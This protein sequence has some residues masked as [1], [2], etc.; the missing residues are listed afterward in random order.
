MAETLIEPKAQEPIHRP[1]QMTVNGDQLV[2]NFFDVQPVK[3]EEPQKPEANQPPAEP[4]KPENNQEVKPEQRPE[5]TDVPAYLKSKWGWDSEEAADTEVRELR[6]LKGTKATDYKFENDESRNVHELLRRGKVKDV[7]DIYAKQ[8]KINN[9]TTGEVTKDN[10][11][12]IIKFG[13]S[14]K[15]KD[16]SA[17]EINYKFNKEYGIPKEP[18]QKVDELDEDFATRKSEWDDK[19]SDVQMSKIIEA[20]TMRPEL[21]QAKTKIVLPNIE[22]S[23]PESLVK[24]PQS[25]EELA[26]GEKFKENW[27]NTATGLIGKFDGFSTT[28]KYKD[29]DKD[30]EIPVS[31][32]LTPEE[33]TSLSERL[34]E[35]AKNNFD[36]YSL[37]KERWLNA[38]GGDNVGQV[39]EDLSWLLY[40]K[41]AS[42][43][44]ATEAASQRLERFI[45]EKKNI[46][47]N[48]TS[49]PNMTQLEN[50]KTT[51]DT[52]RES[53]FG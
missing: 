1:N 24:N 23:N 2:H 41:K 45:K 40:G 50:N 8:E 6:A 34:N 52:I 9:Y 29:G 15:Y 13:M 7:I 36:P 47:L 51:E 43:K 25:P 31:Y 28:A 44:F 48:E 19:V 21:E 20:K 38:D 18:I 49:N 32:G 14:L 27:V 42:Q 11:D 53:F 17:Q 30:I 26:A 46:N 12:D 39:I 5:N 10:A 22:Q 4:A 16:L 3:K 33:K 35:F 37:F